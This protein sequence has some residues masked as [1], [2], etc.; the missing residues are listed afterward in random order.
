LVAFNLSVYDTV[1]RK[2]SGVP[3]TVDKKVVSVMRFRAP[4]QQ[5]D[6]ACPDTLCR[7]AR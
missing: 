2:L 5:S 6:F 4:L 1:T 7:R 3:P